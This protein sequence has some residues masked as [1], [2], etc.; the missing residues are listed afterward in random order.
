M[1]G[2][3]DRILRHDARQETELLRHGYG[4]RPDPLAELDAWI[5][6]YRRFWA[7]NLDALERHLDR[8]A[9][10]ERQRSGLSNS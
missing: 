1:A 10:N 5:A 6:P 2:T 8:M 4:L 9:E 7:N 3:H